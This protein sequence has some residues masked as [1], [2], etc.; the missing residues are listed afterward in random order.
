[1]AIRLQC[2]SRLEGSKRF[3]FSYSRYYARIRLRGHPGAYLY[4][5]VL[6]NTLSS[7]GFTVFLQPAWGWF[8]ALVHYSHYLYVS[9]RA[10]VCSCN[11]LAVYVARSSP[12]CTSRLNIYRVRHLWVCAHNFVFRG[13]PVVVETKQNHQCDVCP[14]PYL[15]WCAIKYLIHAYIICVCILHG[16]YLCMRVRLYQDVSE[17]IIE[18]RKLL[19]AYALRSARRM[20]RSRSVYS[21]WQS[22]PA[23]IWN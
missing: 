1:M 18:E 7:T 2:I 13:R 8:N 10:R 23:T 12:S 14:C 5:N 9:A 17:L 19:S 11:K 16:T 6:H 20:S 3:R 22:W 15:C 4:I 21:L